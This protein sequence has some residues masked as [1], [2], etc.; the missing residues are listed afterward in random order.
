LTC[1]DLDIDAL[2]L[3]GYAP[4][5]K[6]AG[7]IN[8]QKQASSNYLESHE[9]CSQGRFAALHATTA[10]PLARVFV[11][12]HAICGSQ[13]DLLRAKHR[14]NH[15]HRRR[16]IS[17]GGCLHALIYLVQLQFMTLPRNR[18]ANH[19]RHRVGR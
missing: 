4:V 14:A 3:P 19:D 11:E 2:P 7:Y 12:C 6:R 16:E 9:V 18:K 17:R 13:C 1:Y 10:S 5:P 8:I 15:L